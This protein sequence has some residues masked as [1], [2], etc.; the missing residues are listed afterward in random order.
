MR[1]F[2][3]VLGVS[4]A[5][6]SMVLTGKRAM[7]RDRASQ[8]ANNCGMGPEERASFLGEGKFLKA[9]SRKRF[10]IDMNTF[11][12]IDDWCHFAILSLS[13]TP[14]N[15]TD[16]NRIAKSLG[17]SKSAAITA[18][19]RLKNLKMIRVA[20][21]RFFQV[22]KAFS[23]PEDIA[24]PAIKRAHRSMLEKAVESLEKDPVDTRDFSSVT[25]AIN[26]SR[27][28]EAKTKIRAFRQEVMQLLEAGPQD[29][30]YNL[31]I[32]LFPLSIK[33][34]SETCEIQ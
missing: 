15:Y 26:S 13:E 10:E 4:P 1:S 3:R 14:D 20:G 29:Q 21:D 7:S 12:V 18:F 2:S 16:E 6:L 23:T 28:E 31:S 24:N 32:Q 30:V 33:G 9:V 5:T 25:M 11:K 19:D 22:P 17:I 8:I 27:I 34:E